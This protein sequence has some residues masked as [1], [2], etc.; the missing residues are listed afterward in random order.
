MNAEKALPDLD[1]MHAFNLTAK[2]YRSRLD[3]HFH[4]IVSWR[5]SGLSPRAWLRS[6]TFSHRT[7]AFG[8]NA[9]TDVSAKLKSVLRDAARNSFGGKQPPVPEYALDETAQHVNKWRPEVRS[10]QQTQS[11]ADRFEGAHATCRLPLAQTVF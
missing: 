2:A 5:R 10:L 9:T 8:R 7:E 4:L 1:I 11:F 6:G 3:C